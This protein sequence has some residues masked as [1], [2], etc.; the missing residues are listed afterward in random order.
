MFT[1]PALEW[2]IAGGIVILRINCIQSK[3]GANVSFSKLA[4]AIFEKTAEAKL[5][6]LSMHL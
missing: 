5:P 3:R 1:S 2:L 6:G 4:K